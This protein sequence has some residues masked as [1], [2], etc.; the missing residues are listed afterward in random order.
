[1]RCSICVACGTE[2]FTCSGSCHCRQALSD[3]KKKKKKKEEE[4]RFFFIHREKDTKRTGMRSL[5]KGELPRAVKVINH[6]CFL[7]QYMRTKEAK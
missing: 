4:G 5:R 7:A 1:M 2:M 6:H 3:K